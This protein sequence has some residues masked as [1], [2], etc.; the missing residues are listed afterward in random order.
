MKILKSI[1]MINYKKFDET[2]IS[3]NEGINILIGDNESGKSSILTAID[4]ILSGSRYKLEKIGHENLFN[5][6]TISKFMS[7]SK[8]LENLP[9]MRLELYLDYC[10]DFLL[11]GRNNTKETDCS[12]LKIVCEPIEEL[13]NEITEI[14]ND[15]SSSFPFEYYSI[16]F[17]TFADAPYTSYKKFY[18]HL[19]IDSSQINNDHATKEYIKNIY[20][21]YLEPFERNKNLYEYRN[22][23]E[24]FKK[25]TLSTINERVEGYDFIIKNSLQANLETDISISEDGV[26]IENKG[27]GKQSFIKTEFA[28]QQNKKKNIDIVLLEEPEN[29]LSHLN[30]KRLINHIDHAKKSQIFIATHSSLVASRLNLKKIIL[31]NSNN[32]NTLS[33]GSVDDETA[34]FFMKS[35]NSNLLEYILSKKV[36]LVEGHA[37]YILIEKLYEIYTKNIPENDDIHIIAVGGICFKRYLEIGNALNIKTAVITDNDKNYEC[38]C[39][40]KYLDYVNKNIKIFADEDDEIYTFEKSIYKANKS[41]CDKVMIRSTRQTLTAEEYMLKNKSESAFVLLCT[42]KELSIPKYIE[43]AIKW[44]KK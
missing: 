25:N 17:L 11:D 28:L 18:K 41:I 20:S 8:K 6:K 2:E 37:E 36:I 23:K 21:S 15:D 12:G 31:L 26:N 32:C 39:T 33:L 4:L 5:I 16:K 7:S 27:K 22:T 40:Q 38:N 1:K 42:K 19:L 9:S 30:M 29:H 34:N 24:R 14:L 10:N 35:P 44:I 43:D 13:S 3:F